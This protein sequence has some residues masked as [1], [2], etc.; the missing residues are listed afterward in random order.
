MM[1]KQLPDVSQDPGMK[2]DASQYA[3]SVMRRLKVTDVE[4]AIKKAYLVGA[5]NGFSCGYKYAEVHETE[6]YK[7]VIREQ[8]EMIREYQ[9]MLDGNR[10]RML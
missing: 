8:A 2:K 10:C 9:V 4:E 1:P 5:K 7:R 3:Q 6:E